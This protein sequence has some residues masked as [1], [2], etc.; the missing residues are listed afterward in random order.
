MRRRVLIALFVLSVNI[1]RLHGDEDALFMTIK[2]MFN[3]Y[4]NKQYM[5]CEEVTQ[6]AHALQAAL[7]AYIVG[8]PEDVIIGLLLHD[9]GQI[10]CVEH[11]G[12]VDYLHAQ[13]DKI[14]ADFLQQNGFPSFV[15][16]LVRFHTVAKVILCAEDPVYFENL[17]TASQ[18]SYLIQRDKYLSEEGQV[19]LHALLNHPRIIDLKV[20]RKCDDMAKIIGLSEHVHKGEILLP[21]FDSY[22]AMMDRVLNSKG[23][24]GNDG[25]REKI[26][27]F[28]QNMIDNREEFE[29]KF[30]KLVIQGE[31]I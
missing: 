24:L 3:Q 11:I 17:S 2:S 14:G 6:I 31:L 22:G 20:A 21:L 26:H 7:I 27:I 12:D 4:G 8:A 25:W 9:I 28:Y 23:G 10:A 29:A 16:D 15:S 13:H 5:I 18:V 1:P 19:T 30:K